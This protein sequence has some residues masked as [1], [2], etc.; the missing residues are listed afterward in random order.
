MTAR[1][2]PLRALLVLAFIATVVGCTDGATPETAPPEPPTPSGGLVVVFV[3]LTGGLDA[4]PDSA[5]VSAI[6]ED[7][8]QLM[9]SAVPR[10]E[11][12]VY[13]VDN[14]PTVAP[15][16][17]WTVP[18]I[19]SRSSELVTTRAGVLQEANDA[20]RRVLALYQTVYSKRTDAPLT[21]LL[22]SL[23]KAG[24]IFARAVD[25]APRRL[26][27]LS[28]MVEECDGPA[29]PIFMTQERFRTE[30]LE[31]YAPEFSPTLFDGVELDVVP[32]RQGAGTQ[33]KAIP[34]E[35][36]RA[37]WVILF[38]A[39]GFDESTARSAWDYDGL[40]VSASPWLPQ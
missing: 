2:R 20:R 17:T 22:R 38:R 6:A 16:V 7:V 25:D 8:R 40:D 28:D 14:S 3:D 11:I 9:L 33:S 10:T 19:P 27:F 21:C 23:E 24:S 30:A 35:D 1:P 36:L 26:V 32:S 39:A 34:A 31:A 29:G 5:R 15:V 4:G 37:A 12:Q 13:P 18:D